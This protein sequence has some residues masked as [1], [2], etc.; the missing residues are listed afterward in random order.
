MQT[1][2]A[3]L[4][5]ATPLLAQAAIPDV[6][7]GTLDLSAIVDY[8]GSQM[9]DVLS[10]RNGVVTVTT[11]PWQTIHHDLV[12]GGSFPTWSEYMLS[13]TLTPAAGY[14][15]TGY[16]ISASVSGVLE[17]PEKPPEAND[18]WVPGQASNKAV[19]YL[20]DANGGLTS[21]EIND[22]TTATPFE[23]GVHGLS[24]NHATNLQ[25]GTFANAYATYAHWDDM[26]GGD[27]L[28]SYAEINV[29]APSLTIYT[30]LAPVPEPETWGM[31]LAG[32][33]M[34]GMAKRRRKH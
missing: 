1:I 13:M 23:Y 28:S 14:V 26:F 17:T 33:A 20:Q 16:S 12:A 2:L 15:I 19:I 21:K 31:L 9:L 32:V 29:S 27:R 30:A 5:V 10:A 6:H 8:S 11:A 22:T 25:F 4:A 24:I 7:T 18:T 34:I 3:A